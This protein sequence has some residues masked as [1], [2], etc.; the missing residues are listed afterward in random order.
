MLTDIKNAIIN[1]RVY[2]SDYFD[3]PNVTAVMYI[4]RFCFAAVAY[5][6]RYA[7]DKYAAVVYE[8]VLSRNDKTE[9]SK[10]VICDSAFEAMSQAEKLMREFAEK[11]IMDREPELL[12]VDKENKKELA[13]VA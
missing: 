11:Q 7:K 12:G 1:W 5:K 6:D 9:E 10:K 8:S 2:H 13:D 3:Q 4:G